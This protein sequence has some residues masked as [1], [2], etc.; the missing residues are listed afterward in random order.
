MWRNFFAVAL[1]TINKNKAFTLINVSGLAIGMASSILILLFIARELSFDRF[2]Q[3]RQ[4]IYRLYIDGTIGDQS[5]RRASSSMLMAPA[6]TEEIPGIQNFLRFDVDPQKL[7]WSDGEKHIEDHFLYADSTLA[8]LFTIRFVRGDPATA[9]IRPYSIVITEEKARLYFGDADPLG[10]ILFVNQEQYSFRVTGV[11]EALPENSHFFADFFASMSTL[12][13]EDNASWFLSSIFSYVLL[14][15]DAD[16]AEVEQEMAEV[17]DE[18]IRPELSKTLGI[19]PEEWKRAGNEYGVYLQPLLQ[20][21]LQPDIE[22]GMDSCFR[23][24][25]D[26]LYL[27]IFGLVACFILLIAS[28]NFMNLSTA[29]AGAR[30]RETG[31]RKAA[32]SGRSLLVKQFLTESVMLSFISL[33]MAMILVELSLRG[34]NLAMDLDLRME[35]MRYGYFL[36]FILLLALVVGLVSGIYPALYISRISPVE[37]IK[38][39]MW[40]LRNSGI[41]RRMLVIAQ[42]TISVGIIVGTLIVS[43]QLHYMLNKDLG[44]DPDPLV[45]LPR[46]NP[47]GQGVQT[48]C[49]EVEKI[50]GIVSASSSTT[51]LGFNNNTESYMIEGREASLNFL[52]ETNYVDPDFMRTYRFRL[53]GPRNRFFDPSISSDRSAILINR[54]AVEEFEIEDPFQAVI[55]EPGVD[56]D[57]NRLHVIGVTEDFHHSSL[58]EAIGPYMIRYKDPDLPFRYEIITLRLDTTGKEMLATLTRVRELWMEMTVEAPFQFFFLDEEL[59]NYYKEDRRTAR[60]SLLFAILATFIACLG[61]FGLTLYNT[62]RRRREIGIRKAM[63]ATI[64]EVMLVV[65]REI[66][67]LMIVSVGL[68]WIAAYLFM[69]QWLQGFPFNIGFQPWIYLVA[70]GSAVVIALLTVTLLAWRSA[71]TNPARVL[72]YE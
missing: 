5:F 29:R 70:A 67:L 17:M 12:A 65:S 33:A 15:P 69:Q 37:G 63:G 11:I 23:P 42:F 61:L 32:G 39:E 68:A 28:I 26:P 3:N 53:A 6:F 8:D 43:Q 51:Y 62:R 54:A 47:L 7:I 66:L 14:E 48:F 21:H 55:L 13:W 72:H 18:H 4:R 52:F 35:S 41:F 58:R 16:P 9:L 31:L 34:F 50:P 56:G 64:G 25:N 57:T 49:R 19:G 30:A 24:V 44:F 20:I 40:N 60:I 36:P 22:V 45:V 2:H 1:R 27:R 71:R 38:G 59:D 46:I 10:Q